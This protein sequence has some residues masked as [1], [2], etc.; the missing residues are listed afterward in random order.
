MIEGAVYGS[1]DAIV[2]LTVCG[3]TGQKEQLDFRIDTGFDGAL[4]LHS[5]VVAELGLYSS[6]TRLIG[7][8]DGTVTECDLCAGFVDWNGPRPVEIQIADTVLLLGMELLADHQVRIDVVDGGAVR[9]APL[10]QS[11]S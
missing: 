8:A 11:L 1:T 3:T 7:L 4:T 2:A 6:G 5:A 9:I 10:P